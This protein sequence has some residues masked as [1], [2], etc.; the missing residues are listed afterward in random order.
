MPGTVG[1]A[2]SG[3]SEKETALPLP[4]LCL[5]YSAQPRMGTRIEL[6]CLRFPWDEP[7]RGG[8]GSR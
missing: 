7:G 6:S 1:K 5:Q 2:W 4:R 8:D 3:G